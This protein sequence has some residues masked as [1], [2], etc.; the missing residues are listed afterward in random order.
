MK[1]LLI[2]NS[3]YVV[4]VSVCAHRA[5][6]F[7][8]NE[9]HML[10]LAFVLGT[11]SDNIDASGVDARVSENVGKLCNIFFNAVEGAGK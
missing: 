5:F 2:H 9:P 1:I 8:Y 10:H 11:G 7:L 3:R 4:S 6:S